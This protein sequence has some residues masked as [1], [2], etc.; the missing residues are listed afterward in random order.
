[1][2]GIIGGMGPYAGVRLHKLILKNSS[3]SK[4]QEHLPVIHLNAASEIPDRTDFLLGKVSENPA[5]SII[6]QTDIIV[7]AGASVIGLPC[8]T[9]HAPRIYDHVSHHIN[10]THNGVVLINMVDDVLR[11]LTG[12]N[13]RRA[14]LLATLGTYES[15]IYRTYAENYHVEIIYPER[16]VRER[17][18]DYIYN[19]SFGLKVC[20]ELNGRSRDG[21]DKII[22]SFYGVD[23]LILGCTEIAMAFPARYKEMNMIDTLDILAQSLISAYLANLQ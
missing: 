22:R 5:V 7:K 14:G 17:I 3:A 8:N 10:D 1:M 12:N 21:F 19:P 20:G 11:F 9:A 6:K 16:T 2:I 4:D 18:Q 23:T 15:D 13:I